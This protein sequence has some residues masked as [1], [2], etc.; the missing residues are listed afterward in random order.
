MLTVL[1]K[2][3]ELHRPYNRED[4]KNRL[5]NGVYIIIGDMVNGTTPWLKYVMAHIDGL[6]YAFK[7]SDSSNDTL[8]LTPEQVSL[9]NDEYFSILWE[10][11]IKNRDFILADDDSMLNDVDSYFGDLSHV[12]LKKYLSKH[13]KETIYVNDNRIKSHFKK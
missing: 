11:Y 2:T 4:I 12:K 3:T 8:V 6:L 1:T 5:D 13:A 10:S 9:Y 7:L